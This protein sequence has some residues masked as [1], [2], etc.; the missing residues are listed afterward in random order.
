MMNKMW[1]KAKHGEKNCGYII[2]WSKPSKQRLRHTHVYRFINVHRNDTKKNG[3]E[4]NSSRI[5]YRWKMNSPKCSKVL[6]GIKWIS[7]NIRSRNKH[8][9]TIRCIHGV[10]SIVPFQCN[11]YLLHTEAIYLMRNHLGILCIVFLNSRWMD[12]FHSL[13]SVSKSYTP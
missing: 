9:R 8:M 3:R 10:P 13:P 6:F 4:K 11:F 7:I 12:E 2:I 5:S 1:N